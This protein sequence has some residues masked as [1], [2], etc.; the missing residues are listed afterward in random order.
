LKNISSGNIKPHSFSIYKPLGWN[1]AG[2][3]S[4]LR[5]VRESAIKYKV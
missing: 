5:E 2:I 1:V 3:T 4:T